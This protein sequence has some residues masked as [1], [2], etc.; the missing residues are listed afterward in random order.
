MNAALND[1][2]VVVPQKLRSF[3]EV[4]LYDEL[5]DKHQIFDERYRLLKVTIQGATGLKSV[6]CRQ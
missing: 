5:G 1:D 3:R 6:D 4:V 2:C